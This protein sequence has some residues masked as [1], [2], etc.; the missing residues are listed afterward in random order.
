MYDKRPKMREIPDKKAVF[1]SFFMIK[2]CF[3]VSLPFRTLVV[4]YCC[5]MFTKY[6][7]L[8]INFLWP[9]QKTST[10]LNQNKNV[11]LPSFE[12]PWG[13]IILPTN[14]WLSSAATT[15]VWDGC[16]LLFSSFSKRTDSTPFICKIIN[17]FI[18]FVAF[19][20]PTNVT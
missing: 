10:L 11:A 17:G 20:S 6:L 19:I 9:F 4:R 7:F 18:L 14:L 12:K 13:F 8:V 3:F 5:T 15:F 16:R 2:H 1:F